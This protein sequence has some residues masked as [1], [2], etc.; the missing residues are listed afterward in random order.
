VTISTNMA[1]RGTDIKLG[2]ADEGERQRVVALGGLYVIGTN[3]HESTRIDMQLRGRAGRQGDPGES[4]FFISLE[5]E[6]I[7]RYGIDTLLA[8]RHRERREEALDDPIVNRRIAWAQRVVEGQNAEIRRTLWEY[9]ML[10]ERQRFAVRRRREEALGGATF[11]A[12]RA[13]ESY[14]ALR[15]RVG[16]RVGEIERQIALSR[17]DESWAEHLAQIAQTREGIHMTRLAGRNPLD[18]FGRTVSRAFCDMMPELDERIVETFEAVASAE[19]VVDLTK[20]G[21]SA[22]SATWTYLVNDNPFQ[23]SLSLLTGHDIGLS[24][25]AVLL[26][27]I[28]ML[29]ALY[30]RYVKRRP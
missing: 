14:R 22:P 18:E 1:G 20:H 21:V 15:A 3:R 7:V 12:D 25:G 5:D 10:V 24:I 2:G 13:P 28:Y 27:P 17:I 9:S 6:L 11:C 4:R 26:G 16:E 19:G 30:A 23:D 29:G 8:Q